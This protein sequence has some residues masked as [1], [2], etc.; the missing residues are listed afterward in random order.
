MKSDRI[1]F[2]TDELYKLGVI[3]FALEFYVPGYFTDDQVQAIHKR[4]AECGAEA[5]EDD[6]LFEVRDQE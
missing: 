5:K 3:D 1:R 4:L 2:L 6:G